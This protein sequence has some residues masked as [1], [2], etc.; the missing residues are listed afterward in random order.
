MASCSYRHNGLLRQNYMQPELTTRLANVAGFRALAA[1]GWNPPLGIGIAGMHE[2]VKQLG[3]T[4]ELQSEP[5]RGT[6]ISVELPVADSA[7][8]ADKS[9]TQSRTEKKPRKSKAAGAGR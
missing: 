6:L 1:T 2:R 4:L 9:L 7:E 8:T 3:G 5:G